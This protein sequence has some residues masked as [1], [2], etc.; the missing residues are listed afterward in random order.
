MVILS[1]FTFLAR[2]AQERLEM[3]HAEENALRVPK[4][5]VGP[6]LR[7]LLIFR[8]ISKQERGE[9]G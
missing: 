8:E 3:R 2:L 7:N 5:V 6:K 9:S 4:P 1:T